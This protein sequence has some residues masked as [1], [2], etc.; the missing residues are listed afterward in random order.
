MEVYDRQ[1][2]MNLSM[3]RILV[4]VSW[5]VDQEDVRNF[6][7]V[8]AAVKKKR[9]KHGKSDSKDNVSDPGEGGTQ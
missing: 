9:R 3:E 1:M 7:T 8:I 2:K 6:V 5:R 4:G